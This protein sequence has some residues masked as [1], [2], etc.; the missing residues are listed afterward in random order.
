MVGAGVARTLVLAVWATLFCA[1]WALDEGSRYLGPRT[2]WVIPFGAIAL[3][4]ATLAHGVLAVV[5]RRDFGA[6]TRGEAAGALVIVLPILAVLAVPSPELGAQAAS[7]KRTSNAVLVSQLA[8]SRERAEEEPRTSLEASFVDI[9]VATMSPSEGAA[10]GLVPG[11]RVRVHGLVVHRSDVR[12]TFGLTRFFISCCAADALPVIVP[13]DAGKAAW[14][15][16]DR[17]QLVDGT[18]ARRGA[19]LVVV[20][21]RLQTTKE[22][23]SP[24]VSVSDGGGVAVLAGGDASSASAAS[25]APTPAQ[26]TPAPS[27]EEVGFRGRAARVYERYY[28]H[29]KEF[30]YEALAFP[31]RVRTQ[32]EAAK[33]FAGPPRQFQPPAYRGCLD[34]LRRGEGRITVADVIKALVAGEEG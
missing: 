27:G 33:L 10:M 34:G 9:A 1:L 20:A 18:L 28:V 4:L 8:P 21:D 25:A 11:A 12:G 6:L 24:Y 13:V 32:E 2:Q 19:G 17:W 7:K 16:E 26:T 15:P 23:K 31:S 22:P 14:P 5:R 29:C 3:T 30:T